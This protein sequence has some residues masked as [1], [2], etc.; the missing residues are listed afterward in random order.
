MILDLRDVM[1]SEN[2]EVT[3]TVEIEFSSFESKLGDFPITKKTPFELRL[4]NEENKRLLIFGNT[5]VTL[6]IPCGRC[7][8]DVSTEVGLAIEK[9]FSLEEQ[10]DEEEDETEG[11]VNEFDLDVDRLIYGEILVNWPMKVLCKADCKGICKRCGCNLN[12]R[13]CDCQK[14]E[15]DPRMAAIQE[16]G[17]ASC[18][19]RV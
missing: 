4:V 11:Y 1:T 13:T 7:L 19:E 6:T 18:R 9:E 2:K 3:K 10:T 17:R 8:E 5:E 14:T 15:L 16:I 12:L